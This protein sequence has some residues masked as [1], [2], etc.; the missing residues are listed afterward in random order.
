M[1]LLRRDGVQG[2]PDLSGLSGKIEAG[3][4]DSCHRGENQAAGRQGENDRMTQE[5]IK[6][7]L[8]NYRDLHGEC[9]R[10]Q[11]RIGEKHKEMNDL[12]KIAVECMVR[13][14]VT[15]IE[16]VNQTAD[17]INELLAHYA[18]MLEKSAAAERSVLDLAAL[19]DDAE[20]RKILHLHY[21]EGVSVGKIAAQMGVVERTV[22]KKQTKAIA[23][24]AQAVN[25]REQEKKLKDEKK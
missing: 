21:I 2:K 24:I 7:A 20:E 1:Y 13:H 12:R 10:I 22:W 4:A 14:D 5:E 17:A 18:E 6:R 25:E 15:I 3:S 8:S 16:R 9:E 23:H 19:P 11:K